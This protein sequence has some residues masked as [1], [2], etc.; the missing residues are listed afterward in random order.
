MLLLVLCRCRSWAHAGQSVS[1][2]SVKNDICPPPR[3]CDVAYEALFRSAVIN[4]SGIGRQN[5]VEGFG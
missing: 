5:G 1:N 2:V 4:G 3:A